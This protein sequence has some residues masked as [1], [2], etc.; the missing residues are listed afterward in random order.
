LNMQ[1]LAVAAFALALPFSFAAAAQQDAKCGYPRP[2]KA[3]EN[4]TG[5]NGT[6]MVAGK[7]A[8][9]ELVVID[10]KVGKGEEVAARTAVLVSYTGWLYDPCAP[11]N[12]GLKFDT[13]EGRVTPLG[14]M[15]GVGRVIKGW[16]E[17]VIGMKKGGKRTLIIPPDKAYGDKGAGD[18]IPP[19]ATL[20]FDIE[21]VEIIGGTPTPP[22]APAK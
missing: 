4:A 17:G 10:T 13:S 21:L 11:D 7:N 6:V 19:N 20:V 2:A 3:G 14:F 16:D 8:P 15:V 12:K 5:P 9:T 1:K 22:P 18:K